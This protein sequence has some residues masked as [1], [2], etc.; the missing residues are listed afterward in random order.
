MMQFH[1][2]S[3]LICLI[4]RSNQ[5]TLAKIDPI[6]KY[7][8]IRACNYQ[9]DTSC[10]NQTISFDYINNTITNGGAAIVNSWPWIVSIWKKGSTGSASVFH[11]TGVLIHAQYVLTNANCAN[12]IVVPS[13]F[14]VLAGLNFRP[15]QPTSLYANYSVVN[16]FINPKYNSSIPDSI[17]Y[18]L[19]LL[20][21]KTQVVFATNIYPICL[22]N[23]ADFFPNILNSTVFTLSW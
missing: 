8:T 21:L 19:A 10:G 6:S 7:P 15:Q 4:V 12:M 11:C 13:Q 16:V 9:L 1:I 23:S 3:I 2:A 22:P 5:Q 18:N 17:G 14:I 20:K